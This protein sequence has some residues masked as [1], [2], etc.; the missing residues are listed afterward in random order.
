[1]AGDESGRE[2]NASSA[3]S[4]FADAEPRPGAKDSD[5]S[6]VVK[7]LLFLIDTAIR[8]LEGLRSLVSA[9]HSEENPKSE[10]SGPLNGMGLGATIKLL[11]A[12][13]MRVP[14]SAARH[15]GNFAAEALRI[16]EGTSQVEPRRG[17][18]RFKDRLWTESDLLRVLL[19][20]Y[21]SLGNAAESWLEEQSLGPDDKKRIHFLFEQLV[22]AMAPS[23]LPLNPAALRRAS[24]TE[25]RSVVDGVRHLVD[26]VLHNRA[27]PRQVS[28]HAYRV[29]EHL[30][31]TPGAVVHRNDQLELIQY[32]PQTDAV[33]RQPLLVIP[34]QINKFYSFDLRPQNSFVGFALRNQVQLFILSW[35]NPTA[36]QAD[37]NL[38]TYVGT[39]IEAMDVISAI[40]GSR[41][42]GLLS[43]CAGGLTALATMGCL[44]ARGERRVTT[45]SL[46]VTCLFPDQGSKLELFATNELFAL[47]RNHSRVHGVMEGD[48]LAKLFAW[49]RPT[50][51][52]WR[53]WINNYLLG[54]NPPPLDILFWDNDSTRLPAALHHDFLEMYAGDVF[55]KPGKLKVL[56]ESIDFDRLCVDSYV[57]GGEDDDLMPWRGCYLACQRFA[58][59]HEFVLSTSGH[60]Q[61]LLRPP[62]LANSHYF[63]NRDTSMSADAWLSSCDRQEGS[64]WTHWA[65]W[66]NAHS[67]ELKRAPRRLGCKAHPPLAPAPGTYVFG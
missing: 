4:G 60:I 22:A 45:H 19:Q 7:P 41:E 58:G 18:F 12:H 31:V 53:Y 56:G 39:V 1:M 29:G 65:S 57:V 26:D 52:V 44:A 49:L 8:R 61:S 25:G 13:V 37:W 54:K 16:L 3:A 50:D 30:G 35:R 23:N 32:T 17:D 5:S 42:M 47:A 62:R 28:P 38:D 36:S 48:A 21:L 2:R 20:L 59:R 51:L 46:M 63:T 67:G 55:R 10:D 15:Y 6:A 11:I 43:A 24:T 66:I 14:E 33:R 64:W 9:E 34:P 27:M 40:T